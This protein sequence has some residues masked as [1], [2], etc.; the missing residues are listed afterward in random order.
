MTALQ[1]VERR[2]IAPKSFAPST[3]FGDTSRIIR[4]RLETI[5]RPSPTFAGHQQIA[6]AA[7]VE[8]QL[9]DA[10]AAFKIRTSQVAM[11]LDRDWRRRLFSQLDNLLDVEQWEKL[12]RPPTV[13]SFATFLKMLI[14]LKPERRPGL[15]AS[16]SGEI[17]A[18]WTVDGDRLT[19]ECLAQDQVRWTLTADIDGDRERAAAITPIA[20]LREVLAPYRPNRWFSNAD[21]L[22]TGQ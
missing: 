18:T 7:S 11:H 6:L 19:V 14:F 3:A 21:H 22:P 8:E 13:D 4:E 1:T 20:R 5:K 2:R 12:D 17:I 9:Y 10:L 15:G 16:S